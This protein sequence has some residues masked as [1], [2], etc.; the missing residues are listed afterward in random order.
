M[1]NN[2]ELKTPTTYSRKFGQ[3]RVTVTGDKIDITG[4]WYSNQGIFY[5]FSFNEYKSC[6]EQNREECFCPQ[7]IGMDC[8]YGM[9]KT[10]KNW[11][12]GLILSGKLDYLNQEDT[13]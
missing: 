12:Y 13:I 2:I 4:E 9:T 3:N 6:I 10:I 5:G 1:K 7:V 11:L 8:N